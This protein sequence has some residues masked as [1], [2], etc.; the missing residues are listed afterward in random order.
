MDFKNCQNRFGRFA[1][2]KKFNYLDIKLKV[3][4]RD[5]NRDFWLVQNLTIREAVFDRFIRL[6][7]QL[8][9]AAEDFGREDNLSSVL[10]PTMSTDMDE[11]LKLAHKV[12][13]LMGQAKTK[14]CGLCCGAMWK[15]HIVH[16]LKSDYLQRR[17]RKRSSNNLFMFMFAWPRDWTTLLRLRKTLTAFHFQLC[18]LLK[19]YVLPCDRYWVFRKKN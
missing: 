6:R 14:I 12:I 19:Q 9:I 10:I 17:K 16:M 5:E 15:T 4:K 18:W 3:F 13:D 7:N 8:A 11:Q 2:S 1:W